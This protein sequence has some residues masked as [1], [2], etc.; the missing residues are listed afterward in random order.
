MSDWKLE[1][2]NLVSDAI[3]RRPKESIMT[4][5]YRVKRAGVLGQAYSVAGVILRNHA[6]RGPA[7]WDSL[8]RAAIKGRLRATE[9]GE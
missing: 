5:A 9:G 1:L 3:G 7:A 6:A 2:Y 8:R 4:A